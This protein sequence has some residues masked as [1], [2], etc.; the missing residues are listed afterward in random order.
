MAPT[1]DR[2]PQN[3]LTLR[4]AASASSLA[5]QTTIGPLAQQLDDHEGADAKRG[6]FHPV[7][8]FVDIEGQ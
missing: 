1:D 3:S 5:Y 7:R 4:L 8:T 2:Q 6:Q